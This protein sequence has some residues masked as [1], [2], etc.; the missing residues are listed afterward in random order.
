MSKLVSKRK[1][2]FSRRKAACSARNGL[3][4]GII[5]SP[6]SAGISSTGARCRSG[7][8]EALRC[9]STNAEGASTSFFI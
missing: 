9:R 6:P 4:V 1:D 3:T 8:T 7:T 5:V 2:S